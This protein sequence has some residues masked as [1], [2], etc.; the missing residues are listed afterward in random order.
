[1]PK[2]VIGAAIDGLKKLGFALGDEP[3]FKRHLREQKELAN[4][5]SSMPFSDKK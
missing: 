3:K 4:Q 5:R 1:M 2:L